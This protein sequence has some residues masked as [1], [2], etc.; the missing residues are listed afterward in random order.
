MK[1]IDYILKR[2]GQSKANAGLKALCQKEL[3]DHLSSKRFLIILILIYA[4]SF[5]S[6]YGALSGL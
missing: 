3:A 1:F 2:Q 6:L 4:T 5:A